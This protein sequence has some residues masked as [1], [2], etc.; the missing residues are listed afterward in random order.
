MKRNMQARKKKSGIALV[1][2]MIFV[3]VFMALS[4]G[5]LTMSSHNMLAARNMHHSNSARSSA[6][7]GLQLIRYWTKGIGIPAAVSEIDRY[8]IV[9]SQL[10]AVLAEAGIAVDISG[11]ELKIGSAASPIVIDPES[12]YTFYARMMSQSQTGNPLFQIV[13]TSGN[14]SRRIDVEFTYGVRPNTVFD[15]GVA[16]RGPLHLIG[17][18]TLDGVNIASESD[19]YIESIETVDALRVEGNSHIA[20][21]VNIVNPDARVTL[22]GGRSSIG[23]QRGLAAMENVN[24]GIPATEFPYPKPK[25]FDQYAN[26]IEI[27]SS[28]LASYTSNATLENVRIE[29]G[30]NPKFTGDVTIKGIMFIEQ[31]NIVEFDGNVD[32]TG[33]II[34]NGD[35]HDHSETNK[36]VFRGNV[37]SQG[38][39]ELPND[40]RYS[41]LENETGTFLIAPGFSLSF[42][43][44]F[45][46]VNGAISGNGIDFFGN[47]GGTIQGSVIN[48]S[49]TPMTVTGNSDLYFNR[50]GI[51]RLPS[52]FIQEMRLYYS[53]ASYTEITY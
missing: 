11:N 23:G 21:Q 13:G 5:M 47:A 20:G 46:T 45:G 50:S 53:P 9:C 25:H 3:I 22:R 26:G 39:S 49:P 34:G 41:G 7:S 8:G 18:T 2:A 44:N 16:T 6:E 24:A 42:G 19:V 33:I 36:I 14:V 37:Y 35:M 4:V 43:G 48:Y 40:P 17:I 51:E 28:N 30:T 10:A 52:G 31:P 15:Y 27:D 12:N 1:A 38:V 32:I 29:A